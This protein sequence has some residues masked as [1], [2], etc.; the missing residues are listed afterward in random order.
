MNNRRVCAWPAWVAALLLALPSLALA[1]DREPSPGPN[2]VF[3]G[4]GQKTD[5]PAL[6]NASRGDV[7]FPINVN[8]HWGLMNQH[9]QVVVFPRFD[10]TDYSFDGLSRVVTSGKTGFITNSPSDD[11]DDNEYFI[12]PQYDYADRFSNGTAVVMNEGRWGMIDKTGKPLLPMEFE[13]VL[14]MQDG[15]A[16]VQREGRCGFVN[17]AGK[18]AIPMKYKRIRSFHNGYAAVQM[19]DDRWGYIDKRG[20]LVWLDDTGR[21]RFLGDFHE[22]YARVEVELRNGVKRW[23]YMTKAF[24]YHIDPIYDD[25]RDFHDGIAG[26]KTD[27]KWGFI[28][29]SRRWEL[30]P[31][32]D[33]VDDFD[34]AEHTND[35]EDARR[36]RDKREGRDLSTAGLYAMVKLD[37]LWGYVNRNASR[38]LVPQFK[39]AQPFFR[40]LARVSR[41]DSFAYVTEVGK[42]RFDP[43]VAIRL[44]FVDHTHPEQGRLENRPED[45]PNPG[46]GIILPPDQREPVRTPYPPEHLYPET[47]PAPE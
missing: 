45:D 11:T 18:L 37:G 14:R 16:G 25:A 46:Q 22:Q 44:G 33:E 6:V 19:P 29:A 32:F 5:Q 36:L 24:R 9:G 12:A 2:W 4:K 7:M 28:N 21:V 15:F 34:D 30:E 39:Q 40:G 1:Q 10:W 20:K 23:G 27:G 47:L 38:G 8:N 31:Q 13:G 35:F 43:R 41:D 17:R 26:V 42:V 3:N